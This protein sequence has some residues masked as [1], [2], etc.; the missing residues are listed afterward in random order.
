MTRLRSLALC[1]ALAVSSSG[2]EIIEAN[3]EAIDTLASSNSTD[4]QRG[5][6]YAVIGGTLA[7]VAGLAVASAVVADSASTS[8][9]PPSELI[10]V[11]EL[12]WGLTREGGQVSWFRCTSRLMC[13]HQKVTEP[14]DAVLEVAAAGRAQPMQMGG[15]V[16]GE[17]DLFALRVRRRR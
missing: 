3:V 10:I 4:E 14:E 13:T 5:F 12:G 11:D 6:A 15:A 16:S 2:C 9:T 8:D 7:L 17:V 1:T